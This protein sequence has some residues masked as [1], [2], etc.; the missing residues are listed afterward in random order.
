MKQI[1]LT[2]N[3]KEVTLPVLRSQISSRGGGIEVEL[4][5]AGWPDVRMTAYQNYLGGGLLGKV[6]NSCTIRDW[7]TV[8]ELVEI[9][10]ALRRAFH[11]LTNPDPDEWESMDFEKNQNMPVSGY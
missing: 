3:G 9:G 10:T 4:S 2:I 6:C 1:T 7:N 11:E 8:P 5:P